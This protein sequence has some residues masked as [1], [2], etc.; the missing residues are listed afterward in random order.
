MRSVFT[1]RP[2]D[3]RPPFRWRPILRVWAR[4]VFLGTLAAVGGCER[5][6]APR[7]EAEGTLTVEGAQ[8]RYWT[9]G[10]G[11]NVI[12]LHGGP[13]LGSGSL[14]GGLAMPGFPPG[15]FRWVAYDQ[16]GSGRSTGAEA[17]ANL[18]MDRFVEDLEAVRAAGGQEK[19]AL[20][21]HSFGGL[22]ALYYAS[23]YPEHVAALILLDPDPASRELWERYEARVDERT[24][25]EA[26]QIMSVVSSQDGWELSP[27]ALDVYYSARFQ[28]YFGDPEV[29]KS[30]VLGLDF[31][32][33][34]NF[35]GTARIV[36]RNMGDWNIFDSLAAIEAP[37]LILTGDMSIFPPEAH[38]MLRDALPDGR[39]VV[40][41]GVG[42]FPHMEAPAAF[43]REVMSLL[44]E[45][46]QSGGGGA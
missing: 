46:T 38:E 20:M 33:F 36:R 2:A 31:N 27:R 30:L 4:S 32:V 43:A 8:L 15:G 5:T 39:L 25:E 10:S 28:A 22:L 13:G 12:L 9:V 16:R 11:A 23:R 45:V 7:L 24:T 34:G 1:G 18:T 41:P 26:R 21:G 40:L 3:R 6:P 42:N 37:V 19:V 44:S 17:P 35:P 14:L 29:S